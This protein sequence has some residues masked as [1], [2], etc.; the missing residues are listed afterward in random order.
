[1]S[2]NNDHLPEGLPAD[3]TALSLEDKVA[4]LERQI[5]QLVNSLSLRDTVRAGLERDQQLEDGPQPETGIAGD[6]SPPL[7]EDPA[8]TVMGLPHAA[9]R[10]DRV[11]PGF[12]QD[13]FKEYCVQKG[14]KL[15]VRIVC[16]GSRS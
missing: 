14:I 10:R 2:V 7:Q 15:T 3:Q 1:M 13:E 11:R 16:C 4:A 9:V 8:Q 5:Q 12:Q 6:A